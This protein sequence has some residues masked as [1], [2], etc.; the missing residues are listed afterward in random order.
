MR[1]NG[2]V[3]WPLR[4]R[5]GLEAA[6]PGTAT[7]FAD[8]SLPRRRMTPH[9]RNVP[10]NLQTMIRSSDNGSRGSSVFSGTQWAAIARSL[11]LSPRELEIVKFIFDDKSEEGIAFGLDISRHTVHSYLSR[12]YRKIGVN[13]RPQLL[14]HVFGQSR[15][16]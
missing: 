3:Q 7:A 8:K 4:D 14:V 10:K 11:S 1:R 9:A 16:S 5:E 2:S 6:L 12:L 15:R 13:S